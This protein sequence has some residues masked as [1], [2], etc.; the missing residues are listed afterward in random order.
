MRYLI[1]SD[2]HGNAIALK[3]VINKIEELKINEIIWCGDYVTDFPYSHETVELIKS[4]SLKYKSYIILGNRDKQIIDYINGKKFSFTQIGN[5]DYTYKQLSEDDIKWIKSLPEE[6]AIKTFDEKVIYVSHDIQEEYIENCKYKI[7]GHTHKQE[8]YEKDNIKYI[9][10]GSVGITTD[11]IFGLQF[12]VLDI[13]ENNESIEKYLF[14]YNTDKLIKG[15]KQSPIYNDDIQWGKLLEKG[16]LTGIDYP[17]N[18]VEEYKRLLIDNN[19]EEDSLEYWK[20]A[21]NKILLD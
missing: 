6:I 8:V 4:I 17:M 7:F 16:L 14:E 13:N 2:I 5:I 10:P 19:I 20:I 18:C 15:L 9:N 3:E 21:I 12:I 11:V 1:L